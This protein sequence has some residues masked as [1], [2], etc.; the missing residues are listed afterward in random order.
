MATR[1]VAVLTA[2]LVCAAGGIALAVARDAPD[3]A[4]P[5]AA[6]LAA[7]TAA[8]VPVPVAAP[9]PTPATPTP[10]PT[11]ATPT[12]ATPTSA[13]SSPR[14]PNPRGPSPRG[15]SPRATPVRTSPAPSA[16]G[17]SA[18]TTF[19]SSI[20]SV[21]AA[22]LGSSYRAGCPV[23][24]DDL[25]LV[26]VTYRDLDGRVREGELVVHADVASA[27]V[28]IF[29]ALYEA[30]FPL[31]QVTTVE[32]FGS[33]DDRVMAANVTSAY[34]CRRTTSGTG[35]SEH[36]Y[37]RAID[38]NPIQNPYVRDGTVEPPAGG[39]YLDRSDVRAGMVVAGDAV[40]R[41]FAAVGWE[42]GGDFRR[43]KDYQHFSAN[44]R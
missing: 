43:L 40:V 38:L 16:P 21:T 9:T 11:F 35:F 28:R 15:P 23:R 6:R 3:E 14:V 12:F 36:A 39:A 29:R 25:R 33:D 19:R 22:R 24:V 4:L 34:N 32:S 26:G 10:T 37:G 7:P 8:P 20:T 2:A 41:A 31:A 17:P 18:G 1:T 13:P 5:A 42:W 44:G 30:D 27:V